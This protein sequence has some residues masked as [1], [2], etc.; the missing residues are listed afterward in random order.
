MGGG[1]GMAR[2]WLL[3]R[4]AWAELGLLASGAQQD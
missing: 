1:R 3:G 2:G 4:G